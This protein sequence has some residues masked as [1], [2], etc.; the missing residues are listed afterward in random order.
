VK[1]AIDNDDAN[2]MGYLH[3]SFMDNYEWLEGYRPE[4]KFGLFTIDFSSENKGHNGSYDSNDSNSSNGLTKGFHLGRQKTKAAEALELIIKRS[5]I[6]ERVGK[7]RRCHIGCQTK[8]WN[9]NVTCS[10]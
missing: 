3:W 7:I 10:F 9:L 6:R 5:L 8:V 2:V 4:A 1:R